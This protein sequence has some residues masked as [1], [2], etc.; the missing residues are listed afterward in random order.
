MFMFV[1]MVRAKGET[2]LSYSFAFSIMAL[3]EEAFLTFS[4]LLAPLV[5]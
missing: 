2:S 4:S 3:I 5:F 1:V